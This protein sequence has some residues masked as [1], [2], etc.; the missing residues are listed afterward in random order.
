MNNGELPWRVHGF[1]QSST[2]HDLMESEQGITLIVTFGAA[3]AVKTSKGFA[4]TCRGTDAMATYGNYCTFRQFIFPSS[5]SKWEIT[6]IPFPC[7]ILT[8]A[9]E[10]CCLFIRRSS[11]DRMVLLCFQYWRYVFNVTRHCPQHGVGCWP[12]YSRYISHIH[13]VVHMRLYSTSSNEKIQMI[14]LT[15]TMSLSRASGKFPKLH[16]T[17]RHL[18]ISSSRTHGLNKCQ[19]R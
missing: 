2:D 12:E 7:Q 4:T 10:T 13:A 8:Y 1:S 17:T 15:I 18:I 5:H 19:G 14:T 16:L 3:S 11:F 6:L 9:L